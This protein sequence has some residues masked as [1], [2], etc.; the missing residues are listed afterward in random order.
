[1]IKNRT[2]SAI[3][4][5]VTTIGIICGIA[6]I[7]HSFFE[8]LQGNVAAEIHLIN[9]KPMIYAIGETNRFW[10]YGYEYAYTVIPNYLITGII[11]MLFSVAV[12]IC[13]A[14]FIEKKFGWLIFLILSVMQYLTGGGAAQIGLVV[15]LGIIA[16]GINKPLKLWQKIIPVSV[17]KIIAKPWLILLIL[18][19]MVFI[20]SIITAIFGFLYGVQDQFI[21]MNSL[22]YMLYLM[23]GLFVLTVISAFSYD[24][25]RNI[26]TK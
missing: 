9:G 25:N 11:A 21:I 16:I 5:M 12:I 19:S 1:M 13:S 4:V 24:S 22:W 10:Q 17:R 6:G 8:I 15:V 20:Q 18:F 7:E 14:F 3:R 26:E 23:I 2:F